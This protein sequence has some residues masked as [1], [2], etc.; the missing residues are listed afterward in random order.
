MMNTKMAFEA[1]WV[2]LGQKCCDDYRGRKRTIRMLLWLQ[3]L[4]KD[5]KGGYSRHMGL[6]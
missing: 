2:G 1:T 4:A 6:A 3:R 5:Q